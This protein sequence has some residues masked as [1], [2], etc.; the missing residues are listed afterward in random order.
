MTELSRRR[1]DWLLRARGP[2]L[3]LWPERDRADA[4][5]LLR[6]SPEARQ[7]LADALVRDESDAPGEADCQVLRRMQD[8]FRRRIA[9]LPLALRSLGAGA[10]VACMAVGCYL[11]FALVDNDAAPELF[12]SAQ[13]VAFAA[14][15]P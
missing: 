10:L 2:D 1:L 6:R 13:T 7:A 3:S 5:A 12:V 9:P 4:L 11:A 14:L 8:V 15:D